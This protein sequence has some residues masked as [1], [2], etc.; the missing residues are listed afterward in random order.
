[1]FGVNKTTILGYL[2]NPPEIR[3]MPNG[4]TVANISVATI[5]SW[6]DKATGERKEVTEWHRIVF[7]RGQAEFCREYLKKGSLVYIEGRLKTRKWQDKN[8]QDHYTTEII[9][10]D[11]KII[12]DKNKS[13]DSTPNLTDD[14]NDI[15]F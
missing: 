10:S 11:L 14:S 8:G 15:P 4:D 12:I 7:Y 9:G 1:M 5:E 13:K 3:T 6:T 2:G